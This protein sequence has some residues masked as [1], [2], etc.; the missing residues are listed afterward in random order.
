MW[1]LLDADQDIPWPDQPIEYRL[2]FRF[3]VQEYDPD[4]HTGVHRTTWGIGSP[5]E[6]D[7]PKCKDG[8][9]GCSQEVN[10]ATGEMRW[11]HTIHGKFSPGH[12]GKL[13]AA[14]FHCHAPTCLKTALYRCPEGVHVCD[15]TTGTLL[16]EENAVRTDGSEERFNEPGFIHQPPCLWGGKEEGLEAPPIMSGTLFAIKTADATYGHHGE[17]A[18]LQMYYM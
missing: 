18:W 13:V 14:H 1:S 10:P 2:K 16:C 3:W 15:E 6:Y 11:V 8:V 9:P 17:M 12:G 7:V 4:Y 5:V